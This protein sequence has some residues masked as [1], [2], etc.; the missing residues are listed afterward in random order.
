MTHPET[1]CGLCKKLIPDAD[2]EVAFG[3]LLDEELGELCSV[4][5]E[6]LYGKADRVASGEG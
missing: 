6:E 3:L 5:E 4:C 1:H 2:H